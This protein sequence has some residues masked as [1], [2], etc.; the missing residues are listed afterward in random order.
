MTETD[1]HADAMPLEFI[2][3]CILLGRRW[4]AKVDEQLKDHGL[5]A[6]RLTVLYWVNEM[7]E[8]TSQ[9]E[10]AEIVG[11]EGPT[12]VRQLHALEA[13]G[14]LERVPLATDRRAKCIRLTPEGLKKLEGV[15]RYSIDMSRQFFPKLER[16]RLPSAIRLAKQAREA[17]P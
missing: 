17:I 3:E 16:R 8:G 2:R 4:R 14:L 12:L 10:L 7:P 6:A 1:D 9:R 13:Q 11:I 15:N 5:T